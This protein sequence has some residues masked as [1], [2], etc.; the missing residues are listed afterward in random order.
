MADGIERS[1]VRRSVQVAEWGAADEVLGEPLPLPQRC[2]FVCDRVHINLDFSTPISLI[3][4][5]R[6]DRSVVPRR[7]VASKGSVIRP[8]V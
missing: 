5:F 2:G 6:R 7:S 1:V 8:T 4:G 3:Y